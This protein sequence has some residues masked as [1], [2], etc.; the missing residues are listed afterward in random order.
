MTSLVTP[1]YD[2]VK[3]NESKGDDHLLIYA[4]TDALSWACQLG[5]ADCIENTK[6]YYAALMDHPNDDR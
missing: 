3:F 4:R 5:V 2:Y 6:R 1:F